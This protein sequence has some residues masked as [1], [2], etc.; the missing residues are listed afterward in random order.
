MTGTFQTASTTAEIRLVVYNTNATSGAI[1]VYFDDFSVGPQTAPL[2]SVI[3]DWNSNLSLT[4]GRPLTSSR[5]VGSCPTA[6][7]V[8][9]AAAAHGTIRHNDGSH[10]RIAHFRSGPPHCCLRRRN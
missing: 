6:A 1:T 2:G 9:Q 3:I 8:R 7:R 10:I 4:M 5:W